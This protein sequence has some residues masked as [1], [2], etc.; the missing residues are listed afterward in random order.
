MK[1]D[2]SLNTIRKVKDYPDYE[3][4]EDGIVFNIKTSHIVAPQLKKTGYYCVWLKNDKGRRLMS[5][6]R[7]LLEAFVPNPDNLPLI[8]HIDRNRLNNSLENLRWCT[9]AENCRNRNRHKS[10]KLGKHISNCNEPYYRIIIEDGGK[11]IYDKNFPK[12]KYSIKTIRSIRNN[13]LL[14][15][16]LPLIEEKDLNF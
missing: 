2:I 8:D 11:R 1:D 14:Q 3:I 15:N 7:I 16:G 6:H 10:N 9:H 13:A 4:S 12:S 5:L